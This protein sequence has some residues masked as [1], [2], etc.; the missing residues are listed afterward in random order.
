MVELRKRD[1]H[2]IWDDL[3]AIELRQL[4]GL[5]LRFAD[6]AADAHDVS[7]S[8]DARVFAEL[9]EELRETCQE[10]GDCYVS[11]LAASGTMHL[12]PPG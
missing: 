12:L 3:R 2:Y 6:R 11:Y 9:V 1:D 7:M 10:L 8:D 4:R 5:L